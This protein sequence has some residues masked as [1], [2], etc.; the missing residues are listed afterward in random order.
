MN[1]ISIKALT[2]WY[3]KHKI[4]EE[5]LLFAVLIVAFFTMPLGTSPPTIFCG[6][7]VGIWLLS[8]RAIRAWPIYLRSSWCWPVLVL[9]VLPWFGLLYAPDSKGLSL[10]MAEKTHYW[11]YGLV[12]ASVGRNVPKERLIQAFLLGMAIN[13][14]IGGLQFFQIV[15]PKKLAGIWD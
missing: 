12:I 4:S 13:A 6:I 10:V 14:L 7:A 2:Y 9:M 8:G 3:K 5:N 11:I 1:W 15:P